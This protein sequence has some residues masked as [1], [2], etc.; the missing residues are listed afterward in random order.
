MT[1]ATNTNGINQ[2]TGLGFNSFQPR[3]RRNQSSISTTNEERDSEAY[4]MERTSTGSSSSFASTNSWDQEGDVVANSYVPR[5]LPN[6]SEVTIRGMEGFIEG[7]EY[8]TE[9]MDSYGDRS[10]SDDSTPKK[11]LKRVHEGA[12]VD[13]NYGQRLD[14]D[15]S[16][17]YDGSED[18]YR[19][20][21]PPS[22]RYR[23]ASPPTPTNSP[24]LNSHSSGQ[25]SPPNTIPLVS[26]RPLVKS[27][28]YGDQPLSQSN[29]LPPLLENPFLPTTASGMTIL[30]KS[31]PAAIL[32]SFEYPYSNFRLDGGNEEEELAPGMTLGAETIESNHQYDFEY[33]RTQ[34]G[35]VNAS[36]RRESEQSGYSTLT[37]GSREGGINSTYSSEE[38][39][40]YQSWNSS[41]PLDHFQHH[42]HPL[43]P[44]I[45]SLDQQQELSLRNLQ[46]QSSQQSHR[47]IPQQSL[48]ASSLPMSHSQSQPSYYDRE[49]GAPISPSHRN[50]ASANAMNEMFRRTLSNGTTSR[51]QYSS[52]AIPISP[53][54]IPQGS[55]IHS[56][57]DNYSHPQHHQQNFPYHHQHHSRNLSQS[58]SPPSRSGSFLA[59]MP[60]DQVS[61]ENLTFKCDNPGCSSAFK[62]LEHLKRHERTHTKE[63]PY[64]CDVNGC[65]KAFR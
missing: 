44:R 49:S 51:Q 22:K 16:H 8:V 5:Y 37:S 45:S 13:L 59:R 55:P 20:A 6:S 33:A 64:I 65:G 17:T 35:N 60:V 11:E 63:K 53:P 42:Q 40:H 50:L 57:Y 3:H 36:P 24:P 27:F 19:S 29:V 54:L 1:T 7:M 39:S 61:P 38:S 18:V 10:R 32:P 41:Y 62:R 23:L 4:L 25:Y 26:S 21:P 34:G 46:S 14:T 43:L 15:S 58:Q 52:P 28:S 12:V 48:Y 47:L 30:S 56:P 2:S 9:R 31:A